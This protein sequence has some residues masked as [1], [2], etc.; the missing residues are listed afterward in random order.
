VPARARA[1]TRVG[2]RAVASAAHLVAQRLELGEDELELVLGAV[3]LGGEAHNVPAARHAQVAQDEVEGLGRDAGDGDDVAGHEAEQ[4]GE[5]LGGDQPLGGAAQLALCALV[6]APHLGLRIGGIGH[7]SLSC[8]EASWGL[9]TRQA[10]GRSRE[11]CTR[12]Y[13]AGTAPWSQGA[14]RSTPA[15]GREPLRC[16]WRIR[17]G[18]RPDLR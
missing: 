6:Q 12:A 13:A 11:P 15:R 10:P 2:G 5:A 14:A 9:R 17:G 3:E 8:L 4:L 16:L 1:R 18:G 7:M